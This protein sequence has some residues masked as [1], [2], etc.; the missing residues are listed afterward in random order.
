MDVRAAGSLSLGCCSLSIT[1]GQGPAKHGVPWLRMP[2]VG[3]SDAVE[4]GGDDDE[5]A[6]AVA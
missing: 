1:R 2:R 4:S 6:V 5:A 3:I